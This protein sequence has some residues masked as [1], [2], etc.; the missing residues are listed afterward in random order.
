M[1]AVR[2]I[3]GMEW[4]AEVDE[5]IAADQDFYR[6]GRVDEMLAG[7][8]YLVMSNRTALDEMLRLWSTYQANPEQNL[9]YGFDKWRR[10]FQR[11][12]ALRLWS[13]QD[14]LRETGLLE[15]WQFDLA[16]GKERVIFEAELWFRHSAEARGRAAQQVTQAVRDAG[17]EVHQT[18]VHE[19]IAYHGLL[20]SLPSNAVPQILAANPIRLVQLDEV[21][22]FRPAGQ[23]ISIAPTEPP[24]ET[25]GDAAQDETLPVGEPRVALLDGLPV[26][27]HTRLVGRLIIDDPQGWEQNYLGTERVHGTAMASLIVHGDLSA[28]DEPIARPIYV[29]P[30]M[31]P[32]PSD[33]RTPRAESMPADQL[34]I[35]LLHSAVRRICEGDGREPAVAPSVRVINLSIGDPSRP[36]DGPLSPFAR[37]LDWLSWRYKVLFMVSAGNA[38]SPIEL[39]VP[40]RQVGQLSAEDLAKA[41]VRSIHGRAHLQRILSPS[42]SVNALTIGSLHSDDSGVTASNSMID[43]YPFPG[44][45]SPTNRIGLGFKR[46]V[47]PDMLLEGGVQLYRLSP[48]SNDGVLNIASTFAI[49]P[50][51][52]VAAPGIGGNLRA[53]RFMS[54]T[55][56]ATAL[57]TRAAGFLMQMLEDLKNDWTSA[58]MSLLTKSLLVHACDWTEAVEVFKDGLALQDDYR[59][60]LTRYLGYG[61][62]ELDRVLE[63]TP[64]RV[65]VIASSRLADGAGHVYRLPLPPSLSGLVGIRRLIISLSWF[66]P[67]NPLHRD[68]RRAGLWISKVD[69]ALVVSRSS[70]QWQTVQRGTLQHEIFEGDAAVAYVDGGFAEIK[71]NCRAD[72]GRLNEEVP[73]AIAVT[74]EVAEELRV[75]VYV[76]VAERIRL[77]GQLRA[78]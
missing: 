27:N 72:A 33:W 31:R 4:L 13:V 63:C 53:T 29:R 73:Y 3:P 74:L 76:E 35:D 56:N 22:F 48:V 41:V 25:D 19:D 77:Q 12:R 43:P 9:V 20:G 15:S 57:G 30:I 11:L 46:A 67:I 26:A 58:Q 45:P 17:G 24:I 37:M 1:N 55:S 64:S 47:K 52:R 78:V 28:G 65:T 49:G 32:D 34:A 40:R 18:L 14:R 71:V 10:I 8:L 51:Q 44:F 7:R 62:V 16:S 66:T 2:R 5:E 23:S 70:L 6:P 38:T 50:G 59:D 60:H 54:G 69:S 75:P 36:L 61:A 39:D 68:Y 42:E 21:M